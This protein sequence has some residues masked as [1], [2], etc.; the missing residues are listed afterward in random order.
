MSVF[1][2]VDVTSMRKKDVGGKEEEEE[3]KNR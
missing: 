3:E 1:V 2:V